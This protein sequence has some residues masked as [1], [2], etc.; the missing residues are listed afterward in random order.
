ML[1][2]A[3]NLLLKCDPEKSHDFALKWL[4]RTQHTPAKLLYSQPVLEKPVTVAGVTFPNPI[5]LAAGLDK[6]G[7]CI[8]AFAAMG[9]GFIEIGTVTPRPQP[10]NPKPRLFRIEEKQAIINRMGFNNKGVDYLVE[11]VKKAKFKGVIG[12]NIGKNK[13]TEEANALEDYLICLNKVYPY[14]SYITVNISSPNTPGLRNLQYGDALDALLK[15]LKDA[16]KKLTE[17]HGRYVPLFIKIAPDLSDE[18]ID[19]I[20]ASLLNAKMDGVIATNTTLSRDAVEGLKHADEAGGL[21]GAVLTQQAERV[22]QRLAEALGR[23]IPIIGVG[24]IDSAKAAQ[25]RLNA[26]ASLVQVYTAFIYQGPS[27]IKSIARAI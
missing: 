18:Q 27:L 3:Q 6:N 1:T 11:N 4:K 2:I 22:T 13:D 21:S 10:G 12:I 25:D 23:E 16:Q 9:F 19:S 24:G 26:G 5:G 14:A 7:D 8:D 15:G 17:T 20:A